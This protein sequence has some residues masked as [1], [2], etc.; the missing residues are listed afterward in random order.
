MRELAPRPSAGTLAANLDQLIESF[1]LAQDVGG[2]S[3]VVY[4]RALKRFK[5]FLRLREAAGGTGY[6][7]KTDIVQYKS[8]LLAVGLSPRTG[9]LYLT[10]VRQFFKYLES[11]RVYPDVSA[12]LKGFKRSYGFNRDPLT[13]QQARDLLNSIDT[14]TIIGLRDF[15][16]INLMLRTGLRTMEVVGSNVGDIRQTSNATL[17]YV[18]SKGKDAKD[19]FVVLTREAYEPITRYLAARHCTDPR[20]PLFVSHSNNNKDKR[21]TTRT[22]RLE[23]KQK[24]LGI[25]LYSSRI[26][27]HSLRHTFATMALQNGATIEQV[28]DTLRHQNITTTQIYVHTTDRLEHA[29]ED[30]IKI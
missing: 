25:G 14:S 7:T 26:S 15:A 16:M 13:L 1:L 17:L 11:N 4:R 12:G 18:R 22:L 2:T 10:A 29:A 23:V 27:A 28:R 8:H 3:K 21:I 24:L 19:D 20:A 30:T 6:L 5:E 9:N